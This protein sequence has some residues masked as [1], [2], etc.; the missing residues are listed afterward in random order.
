MSRW[1]APDCR[2]PDI[3]VDKTTS[4]PTCR[5]CGLAPNLSDIIAEQA[6]LGSFPAPPPDELPGQMNLWW[7]P[8]VK[9]TREFS[10][11]HD[12]NASSGSNLAAN[13]PFE[14]D[15]ESTAS[16]QKAT[17]E[18]PSSNPVYPDP[19]PEN[20][21]RLA[22]LTPSADSSSIIHLELETYS[23]ANHPEYETASYTWGG[24]NNDNT[25]SHPIYIGAY[26]DVVLQTQNCW[27]LLRFLRPSRGVRLAW[28]DAICINQLD[29]GERA[30]QVA[31]MGRIYSQGFQVVV[32]LGDDV[33]PVLGTGKW[34]KKARLLNLEV[35]GIHEKD[36]ESDDEMNALPEK[37]TPSTASKLEK[38]SIATA[39]QI[40]LNSLLRRRYF[41]RLWIIQELILS[42][43][44]VIRVG[45]VD[46]WVD[47]AG[48]MLQDEKE[49]Q[50]QQQQHRQ[51]EDKGSQSRPWEKKKGAS[52]WTRYLSRG[53]QMQHPL[54]ELL[55]LTTDMSCADPRDHVF[56]I[57]GLLSSHNTLFQPEYSLSCRHIFTGFFAH[58]LIDQE[59]YHLLAYGSGSSGA[60]S[61][62]TNALAKFDPGSISSWVPDWRS[63]STW[64][65][66]FDNTET[67]S[68][69][70]N[71]MM[72]ALFSQV[73]DVLYSKKGS[74]TTLELTVTTVT[75]ILPRFWKFEY[76]DSNWPFSDL[77][78]P[79][80]LG[81]R[82]ELESYLYVRRADMHARAGLLVLKTFWALPSTLRLARFGRT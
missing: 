7:P 33:A 70:F 29:D 75:F 68:E 62:N 46:Y 37:G 61:T 8:I 56:G 73:Q 21:F 79:N 18:R 63:W 26:W 28:I 80:S 81:W 22:V 6:T 64:L 72:K 38:E 12:I 49:R 27:D 50:Q 32:Y 43:R 17:E 15:T 13:A 23:L 34:P 77:P 74:Q 52:S 65:P 45:E 3:L 1:H 14:S 59:C 82:L 58:L 60:E 35:W 16:F 41:N 42:P 51:F 4:M 19:L 20:H 2:T 69:A 9:Y 66:V 24:E 5:T 31:Q 36:T 40:N 67:T 55:R 47:G 10:E 25:R 71:W 44:V 53:R 78:S 30:E 54:T 48:A 76:G 39:G 57:M 11:L